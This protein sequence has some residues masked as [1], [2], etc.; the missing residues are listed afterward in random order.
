MISINK[1]LSIIIPLH[2]KAT[3]IVQTLEKIKTDLVNID[4]EVLIIENSSNDNSYEI[5]DSWCKKNL[6]INCKILQS[7]KGVGT[8]IK[9]GI[10]VASCEFISIMPGDMQFGTS[11]I[12]SFIKFYDSEIKIYIGSRMHPESIV[13]REKNRKLFS[14]VFS[15]LKKILINSEIN[16]TMG[17][18]VAEATTLKQLYLYPRTK[19]FFYVTELVA[20]YELFNYKILEIPV[21]TFREINEESGNKSSVNFFV[22]PIEIII[23]LISLKIRIIIFRLKN[24]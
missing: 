19:K 8:A 12:E 13:Y 18:F 16:D 2:N 14:K 9:K 1:S 22:T 5:A 21:K 3:T 11:D 4:Y 17:S 24:Q 20:Y 6:N 7:T 15:F 23:N 10:E